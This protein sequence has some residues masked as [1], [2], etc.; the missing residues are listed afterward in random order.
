MKS[1]DQLYNDTRSYRLSFG[2]D[3]DHQTDIS[4]QVSGQYGVMGCLVRG[5]RALCALII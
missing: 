5:L 4:D 2:G 3:L 1:P